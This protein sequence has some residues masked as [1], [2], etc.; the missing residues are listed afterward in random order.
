MIAVIQRIYILSWKVIIFRRANGIEDGFSTASE[1]SSNAALRTARKLPRLGKPQDNTQMHR[2]G[3][4]FSYA[5]L[6]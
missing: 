6:L 5:E 2:G 1:W 3:T 4:T